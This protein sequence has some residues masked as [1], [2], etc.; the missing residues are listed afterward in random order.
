MKV[1]IEM[2]IT[3]VTIM[4]FGLLAFVFWDVEIKLV[5]FGLFLGGFINFII[6]FLE[7]RIE[8]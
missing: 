3:G 8:N 1:N 5:A 6:S 4:L 2:M 7:V